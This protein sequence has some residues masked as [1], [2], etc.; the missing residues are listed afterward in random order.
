MT[1]GKHEIF[2]F[3][4]A[5][6]FSCFRDKG[7]FTVTIIQ[8]LGNGMTVIATIIPIFSVIAVGWIFHRKGFIPPEFTGP[9]NTLVFFLA[10]PAMIFNAIS[11]INIIASHDVKRSMI[12]EAH[13]GIP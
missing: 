13:D 9:A 6:V 7:F 1:Y 10:I 4:R 5:F 8:L 12:K 3:F 2:L 11:N